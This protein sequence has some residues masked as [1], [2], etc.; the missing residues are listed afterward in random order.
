MGSASPPSSVDIEFYDASGNVVHAVN[1]PLIAGYN[2][3]VFNVPGVY[4]GF[5]IL[6]ND[7]AFGLRYY[8]FEYDPI[9]VTLSDDATGELLA[10]TALIVCG[11][12]R[13]EPWCDAA[14]DI[15]PLGRPSR[16]DG[17]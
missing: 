15:V 14:Q 7:D 13:A 5:T 3:Y 16:G 8:A 2:T 9:T 10:T 4:R 12:E 11:K 1:Q 17:S 6:N